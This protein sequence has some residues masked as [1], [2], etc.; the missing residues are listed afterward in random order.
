MLKAWGI[1]TDVLPALA[2]L[3]A[4]KPLD[5]IGR[6]IPMGATD[7]RFRKLQLNF[8][9][10]Q[11]AMNASAYGWVDPSGWDEGVPAALLNY[12][13]SGNHWDSVNTFLQR[14]ILRLKGQFTLGGPI[15]QREGR[16]KIPS[17][18]RIPCLIMTTAT[19]ASRAGCSI[20]YDVKNNFHE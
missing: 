9:I 10:S 5:N 8:S 12:N 3:P 2:A 11:A 16:L 14:D 17:P 15:I 13:L 1:K 4:D 6:Y 20:Y 18:P 7:L 19:A